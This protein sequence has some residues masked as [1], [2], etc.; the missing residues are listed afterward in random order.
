MS[1]WAEPGRV[2]FSSGFRAGLAFRAPQPRSLQR[3]VIKFLRVIFSHAGMESFTTHQVKKN[4][5]LFMNR[6]N[7]LYQMA[8]FSPMLFRAV[9]DVEA[10]HLPFHLAVPLRVD[11]KAAQN[12]D[13]A[14]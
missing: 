10:P 9:P 1:Y 3:L 2:H 12:W 11:A 13:E 14:H 5:L 6:L 8:P 7:S 4:V